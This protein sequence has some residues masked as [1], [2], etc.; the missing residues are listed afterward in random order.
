[1]ILACIL[2]VTQPHIGIPYLIIRVVLTVTC[3]K[4]ITIKSKKLL[5]YLRSHQKR[6][7]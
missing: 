1:M 5:K 3:G 7:R 2:A 4:F 6:L